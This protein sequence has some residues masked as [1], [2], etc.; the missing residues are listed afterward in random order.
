MADIKNR[1]EGNVC[2]KYYVDTSCICCE[3]CTSTAPGNFRM[4]DDGSSS[5]VFKQPDND[6]ES[7]AC[8]DAK[9]GCPVEAIGD[10]GN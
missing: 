2:G 9:N 4:K 3:A 10:D 6:D 5:M 1:V 7:S 8:D